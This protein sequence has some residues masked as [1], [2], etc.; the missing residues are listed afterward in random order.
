MNG[1]QGQ[2]SVEWAGLLAI[3][4]VLGAV[5]RADRGS[6]ARACGARCPD[7]RRSRATRCRSQ[8]TTASIA[9][10]AD[11][12]SAL[13]GPAGTALSPD[14]ALL[15]LARRDGRARAI[16]IADRLAA[17]RCAGATAVARR[18]AHVLAWP[19]RATGS[20]PGA[21]STPSDDHEVET[22]VGPPTV[23]WV[24]VADHEQRRARAPSPTTPVSLARSRSTSSGCLPGLQAAREA[25]ELGHRRP[26]PAGSDALPEDRRS[27]ARPG[28]SVH[29]R[30]SRPMTAA[31]PRGS[32]RATSSVLARPPHDLA[33]WARAL[34]RAPVEP[35]LRLTSG[36]RGYGTRD[37]PPASR[38]HG[39]RPAEAR[40]Q[41]STHGA[42]PHRAHTDPAPHR[43]GRQRGRPTCPYP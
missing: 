27:L 31:C 25:G 38:R 24:T 34:D 19:S 11:V 22:P 1:T 33:R 3:A 43:R 2:A 6:A 30:S 14:A 12:Q 5:A 26:S 40:R 20:T 29:R 21:S 37:P 7:R 17:G 16:E 8:P 32:L 18:A 42:P 15:A 39:P 35:R 10:I 13:L 41:E 9:D 4:A 23:A 36:P 28:T